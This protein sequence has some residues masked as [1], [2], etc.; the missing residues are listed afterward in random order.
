MQFGKTRLGLA[1]VFLAFA[2]ALPLA[3]AQE[4]QNA[5][6]EALKKAATYYRTQVASHG[7]YVYH[8]SPDLNKRWGEGVASADQ[9]W[10]QPPG[11]PTVGLAFLKAYEATGD[12]FYL[13]AATA[14]GEALVYGQL[15]S[16]GWTNCVDF[17]PQGTRLANYRNGKGRGKNNSS[18]D[19]GQTQSA[20]KLLVHL[21]QAH[22]FKHKA[23]HEA[24]QTALDAL[25]KAQ[26]PIGAF[27]Q[28]WTGP[29]SQPPIAKANYPDYDWRSEGRI[30]EYWDMYTLNDDLAGSV[31]E[32]LIDAHRIYK[33]EKYLSALTRFGD[34][35][36]ASQMPEPQ[37][38]WAQQYNYQMQPIWARKFEPAAIS[39]SE[40]QD[41]L[42][43]L[44]TIA[45]YTGTEKYREPIP[46]ALAYLQKSQLPDG[47][48]A[49]YYEL[50]TNRPLYMSR[51]G[52]TYSLT[53]DDS[54]LPDHYGWKVPSRLKAIAQAYEAGTSNPATENG[55][56]ASD[57]EVRDIIQSLDE[58]G[59]W[60]SHYKGERLVG[61]PKFKM[62][63]PYLSSAMFS[64]NVEK[65]STY[66]GAK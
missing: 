15:K 39:G 8:Y 63:E 34:F 20:I 45:N 53:Y 43:T 42:E 23:I 52:E 13:E 17:D 41:V 16:G 14:A 36:L 50:K 49:R 51:Q 2:S 28:V 57:A 61:Q 3:H 58:Q 11:T 7:G 60:L 55:K 12:A 27:P 44:M 1:A 48:M 62:N 65:L 10:V 9:I 46:R 18:L 30:K 47:Q 21:D 35:L 38:A 29:V 22:A 31:S 54:N 64:Q 33:E 5:A 40:S 24:A 59:R 19:D 25:L 32:T 6:K 66:L 4:L 56:A 26:F 37:P